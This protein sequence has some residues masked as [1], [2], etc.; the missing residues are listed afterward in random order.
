M[1]MAKPRCDCAGNELEYRGE[2]GLARLGLLK[3]VAHDPPEGLYDEFH[4]PECGDHWIMD[5]P[6]HHWAAD[7]RGP[8]VL[9]RWETLVTGRPLNA[10]P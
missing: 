3:P 6:W 7:G 2:A 10:L 5:L 1:A 4:C 8:G 9:R